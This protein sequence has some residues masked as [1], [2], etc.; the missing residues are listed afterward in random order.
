MSCNVNVM[1]SVWQQGE[2]SWR[3]V[4]TVIWIATPRSL[5]GLETKEEEVT[6]HKEKGMT[7]HDWG[8]HMWK[9]ISDKWHKTWLSC[10]FS[11]QGLSSHWTEETALWLGNACRLNINALGLKSGLETSVE[12]GEMDA[13]V[14]SVCIILVSQGLYSIQHPIVGN[15][16]NGISGINSLKWQLNG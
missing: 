12:L 1:W 11:W 16:K 10:I 7:K 4:L 15:N 5:R 2:Q 9:R 14:M 8:K 3:T 13:K 6:E